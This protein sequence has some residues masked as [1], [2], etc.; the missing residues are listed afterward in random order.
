[1]SKTANTPGP[2]TFWNGEPTKARKVFVE[3]GGPVPST[4]WCADLIGF[5]RRAVEVT[6]QGQT[7]FLDDEDGSGWEKVTTGRGGFRYGHRSLPGNSTVTHER[8]D[9]AE[10]RS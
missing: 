1:M 9:K 6:Y 4:W 5:E 2:E 10:G 7:F 3:V 8:A